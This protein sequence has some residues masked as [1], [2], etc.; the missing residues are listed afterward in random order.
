M[1]PKADIGSEFIIF[2][3]VILVNTNLS[4]Y[5]LAAKHCLSKFC[6]F[7]FVTCGY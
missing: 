2:T 1:P 3:A 4:E 7:F 5:Y 6:S